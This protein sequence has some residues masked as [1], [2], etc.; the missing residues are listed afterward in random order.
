MSNRIPAEVFPPGE[1]I[2]DELEARGWTQTDLAEILGRPLKAVSEILTG[3]RAITPETATGLGEAFGVDPQFWMNL[4]SAYRLSKVESKA[5][6]VSRR[7][8]LYAQAPVQDMIRRHWIN[9]AEDIDGLEREVLQFLRRRRRWRRS[10]RSPSTP[11]P[12][13]QPATR[14]RPRHN[15]RGSAGYAKS[16]LRSKA[17][18]YREDSFDQLLGELHRF[19]SSERESQDEFLDYW[20][21]SASGS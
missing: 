15:W 1:F 11:P 5:G 20:R 16:P 13:S 10:R 18:E 17:S 7:A 12:G 2:R 8:K 9:D 4:E 3:K 6:E 21:S 14:K 19:T